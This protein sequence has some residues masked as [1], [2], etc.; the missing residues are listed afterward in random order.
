MSYKI[1]KNKYLTLKL[2]ERA[3]K[4][5]SD[6]IISDNEY[7]YFK[8][9]VDENL[10]CEFINNEYYWYVGQDHPSLIDTIVTDNSSP[11]WRY[12]G[13]SSTFFINK[14]FLI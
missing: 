14:Y 10:E 5:Q 4:S 1:N 2:L 9:N 7:N 11:G 12:T 8:E 3:K 13:I 6:I